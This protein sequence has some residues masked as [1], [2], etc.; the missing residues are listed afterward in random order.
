MHKLT[1]TEH[2]APDNNEIQKSLQQCGKDPFAIHRELPEV[3]GDAI[4]T[5]CIT[6][7]RVSSENLLAGMH[8]LPNS[9][10]ALC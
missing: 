4:T 2:K 10:Q 8:G 9:H 7:T 3:C 1:C 5:H 6:R